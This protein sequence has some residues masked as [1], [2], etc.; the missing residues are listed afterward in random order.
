[1]SDSFNHQ[2]W[3]VVNVGNG[4]KINKTCGG[5]DKQKMLV[6][7][8]RAGQTQS[9]AKAKPT[10]GGSS[11]MS[12]TSDSNNARK[13]DDETEDFHVVKSGLSLGKAIQQSRT[14]KG[15]TQKQLAT[16]INE[17]AQVVQQYEQGLAI[18]NPQV[19]S[20]MERT[21]GTKLPRPPKKT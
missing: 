2:D 12:T 16:V 14:A 1:M 21:L 10:G 5:I 6:K 9:V 8:Q 17:K 13:L 4:G 19:I 3:K 7:A 20:R 15:F 18:P 11:I